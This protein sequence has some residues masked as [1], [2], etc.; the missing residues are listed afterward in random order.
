MLLVNCGCGDKWHKDWINID[1]NSTSRYVKK[2]NILK[3]LPMKTKSVDA[4]YNSCMLEHLTRNQAQKFIQECRRI[5]KDNGILRIVVPDL[6][7]ICTEYLNILQH[8]KSGDKEY[9]KKYEYIVIE[10][11]DQMAREYSGGEMLMYW[12]RPDR[13]EKYIL[14]RTGYPEKSHKSTQEVKI[15]S[16]Y[17]DKFINWLLKNNSIL[18]KYKRGSFSTSGE[19]HKWM[20]DEYSLKNLLEKNGFRDIK[21][22]QYN[23]SDIQSWEKYKLEVNRQGK[24]YKP[25]CLYIEAYN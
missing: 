9:E 18:D 5:L 8:I 19:L 2:H 10:L 3:G 16:Y 24:A 11:I 7:N 4:V 6:E 17:F 23:Q 13:N 12:K 15:Y 1:F 20:Y 21:V 25:N 22:K 14:E